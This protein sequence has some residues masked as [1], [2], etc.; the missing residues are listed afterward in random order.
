MRGRP[1]LVVPRA[2]MH[3]LHLPDMPRRGRGRARGERGS[4]TFSLPDAL[5]PL[6]KKRDKKRE[7]FLTP[8]LWQ[9]RRKRR[10]RAE[11]EPVSQ[12]RQEKRRAASER[13]A[14]V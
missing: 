7:R 5:P 9:T 1:R 12:R 4:G 14:L 8:S 11:L 2:G 13:K 3:A 6:H 10:T